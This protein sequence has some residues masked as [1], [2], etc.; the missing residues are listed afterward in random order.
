MQRTA[1]FK[2]YGI[3]L[4]QTAQTVSA[5]PAATVRCPSQETHALVSTQ[6]S[7]PKT[8]CRASGTFVSGLKVD[9]RSRRECKKDGQP[10]EPKA[11]AAARARMM[12]ATVAPARSRQLREAKSASGKSTPI[13]GLY[14]STPN[15]IPES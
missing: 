15:N 4:A 5:M 3:G 9:R 2:E 11:S 12:V 10:S 6:R 14:V 1:A 8:E 7:K 13:C